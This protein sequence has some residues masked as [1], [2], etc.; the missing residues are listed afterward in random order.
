MNSDQCDGDVVMQE[1]VTK[2]RIL[3]QKKE[4]KIKIIRI[5][6]V[7]AYLVSVSTVATM[8]SAYYIFVWNPQTGNN[9]QTP[10][11]ERL[12]IA[13]QRASS[14]YVFAN[15]ADHEYTDNGR[16]IS[17]VKNSYKTNDQSNN[18][19]RSIKFQSSKIKS[20]TTHVQT[21]IGNISESFIVTK[22]LS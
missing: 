6:T 19:E 16:F 18:P 14:D 15:S 21:P 5:L 1:E 10:N 7:I 11:P 9:T 20:S 3:A 13:L 2:Q 22:N 17:E 12:V 4:R 8:L